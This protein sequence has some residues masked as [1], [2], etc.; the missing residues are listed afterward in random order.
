MIAGEIQ[1]DNDT[2][3]MTEKK[4]E[5]GEE[6]RREAERTKTEGKKYRQTRSQLLIL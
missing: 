6:E 5:R 4:R 3:K 2:Y 1:N